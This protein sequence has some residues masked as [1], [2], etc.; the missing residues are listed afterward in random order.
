MHTTIQGES[1]TWT[2]SETGDTIHVVDRVSGTEY[3]NTAMPVATASLGS[4]SVPANHVERDGDLL[5]VRFDKIDAATTLRIE[6]HPR[7]VVIEVTELSGNIDE[8]AFVNLQLDD[9]ADDSF[10]GCVVALNLNTNVAELPQPTTT[11][12]AT[13]YS[14]F[15]HV[16][17]SAALLLCKTSDC[18]DVLK[19]VAH[20]SD[21]LPVSTVGG[22]WALDEPYNRGSYLFNFRDLTL[23]TVD[24]W[25]DL[26]STLGFSQIDFHGGDSFRF[27][28]CV[29]NPVYYPNGFDDL[30][31]VIDRLNAAGIRAGLHT[32]AFFID[33]SCPWVTPVPDERLASDA[34]FTLAETVGA[35]GDVVA[36]V[37][38]TTDMSTITG[39]FE[40]N[41][42]TLR[43][44]QELV[45][46]TGIEKEPPYRFTGCERGVL[47][48]TA[49][50]HAAGS[51]VFHLKECFGLFVPDPETTLLQ[52][53]AA[54]SADAYNRCGF[55]MIYLD[56][57]DGEDI[58]GGSNWSWHYG[59]EYVW[60]LAARL[61]HPA[62]ME[63][64]TFHHHLWWVRARMGAWDHPTRSHKRFIDLHAEQNTAYAKMFL[65]TNLGWWSVKTWGGHHTEPTFTD[66]NEYLCAKALG[67]G[68]GL[69]LMGIDPG[70]IRES[71]ALRRHAEL[72]LRWETLR[73]ADSTSPEAK[74]RLSEPGAEF[75]IGDDGVIREAYYERN[76]TNVDRES[77]TLS[78]TNPYGSQI[79][80]M[81]V[82]ALPCA[83]PYNDSGHV[84][85]L[86]PADDTT[87]RTADGVICSTEPGGVSPDDEAECIRL[88]ASN[89]SDSPRGAWCEVRRDWAEPIVLTG[90]DVLGLW[91]H[92][93]ESGALLNVQFLSP[94]HLSHGIADHYLH[95]DFAGWRYV[96]LVEPEGEHWAEHEW[97]YGNPYSIYR[98]YPV[99][100]AISSVSVWLNDIP[101]NGSV[102]C[103]ISEV[104]ALPVVDT[105][106][107]RPVIQIG[108]TEVKLPD[109]SVGSYAEWDGEGV[110]LLYGPD[111][112]EISRTTVEG[113]L[114][115]VESGESTFAIC[116]D[117]S[118]AGRARI[119]VGVV[120][121]T[122][123]S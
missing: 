38:P 65:P 95:L 2:I 75:T 51:Q 48:T 22:P 121:E 16:G 80:R 120:G 47:G 111:G 116:S 94:T 55:D 60:E 31:A 93:D 50:S 43:I 53:V 66:D 69:S 72:F 34:V 114:P 35:E 109:I 58:L 96:T 81:R 88:R 64:S 67:N 108:N 122:V 101:A 77:T 62:L 74:K 46:F 91:V 20:A 4:E 39:F 42:V 89:S 3:V 15:G 78:V 30:K 24:E 23:D 79:P 26:V 115:R 100:D 68:A 18:R 49:T 117:N 9:S 56:A 6:E 29:P 107:T 90:H 8:L 19:D 113:S 76:I 106:L 105:V 86:G 14:K 13:S 83:A 123:T 1:Y 59:S 44:D 84:S 71:P 110:I 21:D 118:S 45:T 97:P 61:D 57:L 103:V 87:T 98:E 41:S 37:E 70:T 52:E 27:G 17:A 25:I 5:H 73:K 99:T 104:R 92:G 85:L 7:H 36:V 32:Y 112:D 119:S 40:R 82:E 11:L 33:K 102:D 10:S 28:D 63:M 12:R 54:A